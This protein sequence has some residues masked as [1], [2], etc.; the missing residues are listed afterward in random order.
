MF[1]CVAYFIH[2]EVMR[3]TLALLL[4]F[5]TLM[6]SGVHA[7]DRA[8]ELGN[9][10]RSTYFFL[11]ANLTDN[12]STISFW[13]QP[14]TT[15]SPSM[16]NALPIIVKDKFGQNSTWGGRFR[17]FV[18]GG[19][20]KWTMA[21]YDTWQGVTIESDR[22]VFHQDQ[23]Y[24][25]AFVVVPNQ[26]MKMYVNGQLQQDTD[27]WDYISPPPA[28]GPDERYYVGCWGSQETGSIQAK[29]DELRVWFTPRTENQIRD[30]MC[31]RIQ[32][33]NGL[34]GGFGFNTP[35][36]AQV[37][38]VCMIYTTYGHSAVTT[39]SYVVSTCP[40][41]NKSAHMYRTD[42]T[43]EELDFRPDRDSL[44]LLNVSLPADEGIHIYFDG[45][46]PNNR[47]GIPDTVVDVDGVISVWCTDT[48]GRWDLRVGFGRVQT[49]C[50]NCSFVANR[51]IPLTPWT[52]VQE[53]TS[54]C[55]FTLQ[56]QSNNGM[57]WREQYFVIDELLIN[58][59]M[60]DSVQWCS[61][62]PGRIDLN[63]ST[64][65]E[66]LWNDGITLSSRPVSNSGT[67]WVRQSFRTCS[68]YDTIYVGLDTIPDF[69]W[70]NDTT[71]CQGDTLE[72]VCPLS[73]LSYEWDNG[74]TTQSTLVWQKGIY[75]VRVDDGRCTYQ[76]YVTVRVTPRLSI[77]LGERDTSLCLGQSMNWRFNPMVGDYNW[78]NGSTSNE[79]SVF[80]KPG[81]YWVSLENS[82]F[83]VSD[84][85]TIDFVDCD[86]RIDIPNTFTPNLD[87]INDETGVFTRCYFKTYEF[88][89]MDRWGNRV[90]YSKDP[91]DRWDGTYNGENCPKGVYVYQLSYRRW[92]GPEEP[93][94]KTG[95]MMLVR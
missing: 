73:G 46:L 77:D 55:G 48:S 92:T 49:N 76:N 2:L 9:G 24:H 29:I 81:T 64:L 40:V 83:F 41:G 45:G 59:G 14:G 57:K 62:T 94:V 38:D 32:C 56:N 27:P 6:G 78:S 86:C 17:I 10:V 26:G 70:N 75:T 91:S 89:V 15:W 72:L 95:R 44:K 13:I 80:N 50:V 30:W 8:L 21:D 35:L 25:L 90:F 18:E 74:D 5:S 82:C 87:R 47:N 65:Y 37:D 71:I 34:L 58:P 51:D 93:V 39:Q 19:K 68:A 4:A 42:F 28:E 22:D 63:P 20:V 61:N 12:F 7:Q 36:N 31:R 54:N 69:E 16:T 3:L 11:D 88:V 66:Y 60:P 85:I 1:R 43:D 84:T 79:F 23:W 53:Q 33:V 52:I 67:Y